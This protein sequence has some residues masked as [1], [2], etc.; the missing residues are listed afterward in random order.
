MPCLKWLRVGPKKERSPLGG[1]VVALAP[2][3]MS[4][5][6]RTFGMTTPAAPVSMA[7]W[8]PER[9]RGPPTF[10]RST[11]DDASPIAICMLADFICV[12]GPLIG[13]TIRKSQQHADRALAM[14]GEAD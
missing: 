5:A 2:A 4:A 7:C 1:K 10:I 14:I 3:A 12:S 11:V 9:S 6:E 8:T 13:S